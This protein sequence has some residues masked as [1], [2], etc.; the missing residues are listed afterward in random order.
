MT[1]MK[2]SLLLALFVFLSLTLTFAQSDRGSITG[3]VTDV[4]GA[5]ISGA[6]VTATNNATGVVRSTVSNENGTYNLPEL[7]ASTYTVAIE[8]PNYKRSTTTDVKVAVQRTQTVDAKLAVGDVQQVVQVEASGNQIQTENATDQTSVSEKQVREL[9]LAVAAETGGRTPLAFIFLDS[10]V[11]AASGDNSG[12]RG[13]DATT[14]KVSGA[15]ALG[16]EI[17]IDG[18][19]TRRAQNGT[20]FSEVA[21]GPNAFQEFT[22]SSN[23]YS[24]E[25]GASTGGVVNFTLKS[26][27]NKFHGEAYE[28]FKNEALNA[29][30]YEHTAVT[31]IIPKDRDREN[32]FGGN[33]GGP[34]IIPGLLHNTNKAFF[35]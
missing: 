19:N 14:F 32:D 31:P 18:A 22:L 1:T 6:K 11:T 4:N 20:F 35:F 27:G 33:I 9:P 29:N 30:S 13:T 17:L 21:P 24:A 12:A 25:F 23:S 8:A 10:S 7:P 3:T 15:Q 34:I 28:L 16:T 2:R 26:G 5:V